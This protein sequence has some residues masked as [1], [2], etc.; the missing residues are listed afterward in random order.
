MIISR[1]EC[2]NAIR[3]DEFA[4]VLG[5]HNRIRRRFGVYPLPNEL[6]TDGF[7]MV[8]ARSEK[9]KAERE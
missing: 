1:N 2:V 6:M 5:Y 3:D 9:D 8:V 4:A 7:G